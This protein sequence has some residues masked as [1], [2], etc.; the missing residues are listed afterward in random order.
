MI[1]PA[2]QPRNIHRKAAEHDLPADYVGHIIREE[3]DDNGEC[4]VS[5]LRH[6]NKSLQF[7]FP[8]VKDLKLVKVS[9]IKVVLTS[10]KPCGTTKRQSANFQF[11]YNF[12]HIIVR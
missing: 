12:D 10:P 6:R 2:E 8:D 3:D 1:L 7:Y 11:E 4:E 5:Y 9:D